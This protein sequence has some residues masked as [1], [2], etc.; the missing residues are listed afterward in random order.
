MRCLTRYVLSEFIKIFALGLAAMTILVVLG[1]VAQ[2]AIRR[3][4]PL[5]LRMV[6]SRYSRLT[7]VK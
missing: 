4:L 3:G 7:W 5:R 1:V 6:N 2:E